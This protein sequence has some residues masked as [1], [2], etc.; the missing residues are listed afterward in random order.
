MLYYWITSLKLI[1]HIYL[2]ICKKKCKPLRNYNSFGMFYFKITPRKF[3]WK[4]TLIKVDANLFEYFSWIKQVQEFITSSSDGI[5][6]FVK[7]K[8][9]LIYLLIF[10]NF[11]PF[12]GI[13]LLMIVNL[14]F[15]INMILINLINTRHKSEHFIQKSFQNPLWF[16]NLGWTS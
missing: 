16:N 12:Q 3:E 4:R 6:S 15:W 13:Y 8:I 7:K 11:S 5:Y 9:H 2:Q 10:C 1:F 14:Y